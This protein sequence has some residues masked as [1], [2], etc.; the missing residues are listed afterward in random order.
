MPLTNEEIDR[1]FPPRDF[2]PPAT[3]Q[4]NAALKAMQGGSGATY[5]SIAL[6]PRGVIAAVG[7]STA[8]QDKPFSLLGDPSGVSPMFWANAALLNAFDLLDTTKVQAIAPAGGSQTLAQQYECGVWGYSGGQI[9]QAIRFAIDQYITRLVAD[10]PDRVRYVL[11]S[12]CLNDLGNDDTAGADVSIFEAWREV[13]EKQRAA[14][15]VPVCKTNEPAVSINTANKRRNAAAMRD[16]IR[17]YCAANGLPVID[18]GELIAEFAQGADWQYLTRGTVGDR[19]HPNQIPAQIYGIGYARVLA[20]LVN[21][22]PK[23]LRPD[24]A[25][26][27]LTP[28]AYMAG[29]AGTR[30]TNAD[31]AAAVPDNWTLSATGTLTTANSAKA[32]YNAGGE[33]VLV[34]M[35]STGASTGGGSGLNSAA[36]VPALNTTALHQLI[37]DYTIVD[38]VGG[39][40]VV[41]FRRDGSNFTSVPNT[42][43][44][45]L[46]PTASAAGRPDSWSVMKGR[47]LVVA[48]FPAVLPAA[49][50][51]TL[52]RIG[53][54][55]GI[56]GAGSSSKTFVAFASLVQYA[57]PA[58]GYVP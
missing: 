1:L 50:Q 51:R 26:T 24:F 56:G 54:G 15:I 2:G 23:Y 38:T 58:A 11:Q 12:G 6:P 57:D 16:R 44:T 36:P 18:C 21:P 8:G 33:N 35:I 4:L 14:G 3:Y 34:Q 52:W 43:S 47:R 9:R 13:I 42:A 39:D 45:D 17:S 20:P 5:P 48:S 28:N 31:P 32:E 46:R 25:G 41:Q 30:G 10:T 53:A 55:N 19:V 37:V 49:A 7:D 22:L 29:T 27:V 40:H